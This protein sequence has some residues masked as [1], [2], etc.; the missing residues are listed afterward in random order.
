MPKPPKPVRSITETEKNSTHTRTKLDKILKS[1]GVK[2]YSKVKQPTHFLNSLF[3][4]KKSKSSSSAHAVQL[5]T[6]SSATSYPRSCL[7]KNSSPSGRSGKRGTDGVKKTV[8][9]DPVTVIVDENGRSCGHK[10]LHEPEEQEVGSTLMPAW[11]I[12]R[13]HEFQVSER[14]RRVEEAAREEF[15]RHYRQIQRDFFW[16]DDAVSC[17]SSDLFELENLE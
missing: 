8:R 6:C 2:I 4:S 11:K 12:K 17:S 9:F 10:C 3:T 14:T 1:G 13:S 15:R 7:S 16:D 5:S